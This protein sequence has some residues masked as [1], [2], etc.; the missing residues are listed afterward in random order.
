VTFNVGE[1]RF[2]TDREGRALILN[3]ELLSPHSPDSPAMFSYHAIG[4]GFTLEMCIAWLL[5]HWYEH[6]LDICP[7]TREGGKNNN[8]RRAFISTWEHMNVQ[9]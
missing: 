6:A 8:F 1:F 9:P 5:S 4:D 2:N 3:N 7:C